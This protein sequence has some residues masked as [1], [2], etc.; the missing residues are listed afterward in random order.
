MAEELKTKHTFED[1]VKE[2]DKLWEMPEDTFHTSEGKVYLNVGGDNEKYAKMQALCELAECLCD[3]FLITDKGQPWWDNIRKL[4]EHG[5]RVRCTEKDSFGWL[6]A[7][8][9]K[10]RRSLFFG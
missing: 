2:L 10:D 5:Y 6:G 7:A 8:V 3:D 4:E 1:L 9:D